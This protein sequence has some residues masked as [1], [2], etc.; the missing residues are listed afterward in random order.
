MFCLLECIIVGKNSLGLSNAQKNLKLSNL[1]LQA[2][3]V[4]PNIKKIQHSLALICVHHHTF[5]RFA[6]TKLCYFERQPSEL[7]TIHDAVVRKKLYCV[8]GILTL[9]PVS[10]FTSV[11]LVKLLNSSDSQKYPL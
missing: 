4:R 7:V 2:Q 11:D 8:S 10:D 5:K 6:S 9:V 1:F 3:G